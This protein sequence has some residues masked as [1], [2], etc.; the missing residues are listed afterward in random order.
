[1][2]LDCSTVTRARTVSELPDN[3]Y[4]AQGGDDAE[5]FY[6]DHE[7]ESEDQGQLEV[8][9]LRRLVQKE[10]MKK[11]SGLLDLS[12]QK[13][14]LFSRIR[15]EESR[16][17]VDVLKVAESFKS[18]IEKH[19]TTICPTLETSRCWKPAFMI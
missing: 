16:H 7:E 3:P 5:V 10:N 4:A 6:S 1:M 18:Q 13:V 11:V 17:L 2:C 14:Q 19:S 15:K 8:E 12:S 9:R